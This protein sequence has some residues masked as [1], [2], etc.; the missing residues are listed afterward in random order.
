MRMRTCALVLTALLLVGA[1]SGGRAVEGEVQKRTI[2]MF[3]SIPDPLRSRSP[4]ST[5]ATGAH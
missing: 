4:S 2:G 5:C 3:D 1:C